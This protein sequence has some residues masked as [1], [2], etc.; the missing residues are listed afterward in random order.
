MG[1]PSSPNV[2]CFSGFL[3]IVTGLLKR[4]A[5]AY[6]DGPVQ[7]H[8]AVAG[9]EQQVPI[10][11]EKGFHRAAQP[12]GRWEIAEA[13]SPSYIAVGPMFKTA[14]KPQDDIPGPEFFT[15]ARE[16]TSLPLVPIGGIDEGNADR[17][18]AAGATCLCACS[19]VIGNPDPAAAAHRLRRLVDEQLST[20]RVAT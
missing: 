9:E 15:R 19:A 11:G 14:T 13:S 4:L 16:S 7:A 2:F 12:L 20:G 1:E 8:L 3:K 6:E 18:L 5:G 10:S 17:V